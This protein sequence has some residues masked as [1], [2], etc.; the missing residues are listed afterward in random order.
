MLYSFIAEVYFLFDLIAPPQD[1]KS[2]AG[3]Y[4]LCITTLQK[5]LVL[6]SES[7]NQV[8]INFVIVHA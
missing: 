2:I 4:T 1:Y 5:G 3:N 8:Q 6:G 7:R